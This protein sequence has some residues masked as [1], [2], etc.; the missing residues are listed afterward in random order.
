MKK[1][2]SSLAVLV[3]TMMVVNLLSSCNQKDAHSKVGLTLH[4]SDAATLFGARDSIRELKAIKKLPEGIIRVEIAGGTYELPK[5]FELES[6]DSGTDSLSTIIYAGKPGEEVRISGGKTLI[7]WEK[8]SDPK[9][10]KKFKSDVRGKIYQSDLRAAGISDFGSPGG[11]G[12][13]LFFND[14]PMWISR[15][16]N[17]DFMK[18]TGLFNM[19]PVDVRGTK[20]D[21]VGKFNYDDPRISEW[22]DEKDFWVAGYW[23]WDWSEERQKVAKLDAERKI[24]EVA[25]PYHRY[26]YR[27]GQWFYGFNLLSEID[28]PGEYYV[29][30]EIGILY[31]FPPSDPND[32]H[33]YVSINKN[34]ILLNQASF[35]TL[36]GL[37]LEGCRETSVQMKACKNVLLAGCVLRNSG[38]WAVK[39]DGGA[40]NGVTGCDI[41]QVGAGG[42]RIEA[43]DRKT[44]AS[45]NCFADNNHIHHTARI[46]RIY[47]PCIS[48][49]GVGNRATHN[50]MA[51][52]PHM[53]VYFDGNEHLIEYNDIDDVCYESND[54][55]AIYA[56]RNWTMRGN[57]I[58]YN[59]LHNISG[60]EGKGCVGIYL[61]DA[62]SSADITGNVFNKV[63]RAMMIGGGR[64]NTV[65]NNIFID[66]APSLHIDGRGLNWMAY[67]IDGWI[68]EEQEKGTILGIVYNQPPYSIRYPKLPYIIQD[69]PY[70]PKGN[71]ISG[72]ICKGG[73]WDKPVG[74]WPVSIEE[75]ARPYQSITDNII[76]PGTEVLDSLSKSFVIT[77][78]L[79]VDPADPEKGKFQ[80]APGS[81]ALKKG[82]IQIPFD[83]IG[84][85]ASEYR[86]NSL[87]GKN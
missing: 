66:C 10:L 18:I 2:V 43:G 78:P 49:Y 13:E 32:G 1:S 68:K 70:A 50:L 24:I 45:G 59:Y 87:S 81:P 75:V 23:F 53:A 67:H 7:A 5:A 36:S 8:V 12:L 57:R 21:K 76:A 58:R 14:K 62:F 35:L 54:A 52:V 56:G 71:V 64:D 20:G 63:S 48:L 72:N 29:D 17:R 39:I 69:E 86:G 73:V 77:D 84:L 83:K 82:F 27:L 28:E 40:G 79:F 25:P 16:P 46:M 55:G 22:K 34:I 26:G 80:L 33:S 3:I 37:I 85:Y 15:Y 61:D 51:H 31:F 38:D 41:Y 44:L 30:R 4:V 19:D 9:I 74:F 42:V 47:N 60:F 11:N 6:Q 65:T